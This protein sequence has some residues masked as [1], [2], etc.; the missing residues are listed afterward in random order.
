VEAWLGTYQSVDAALEAL[1]GARIPCAPVLRPAEVVAAAHLAERQFFPTVPHPARG[2][3]RVTASPYHLDGSPVHPQGASPYRP[4]E[5][6]RKVLAEIDYPPDRIDE[7]Q[8]AGVIDG[9]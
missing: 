6:T 7:L 5:H 8:R 9:I 4:G 3:V 1:S 2:E